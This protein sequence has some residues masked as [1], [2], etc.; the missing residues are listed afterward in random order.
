MSRDSDLRQ[1]LRLIVLTHPRPAGGSLVEVVAECLT[2]TTAELAA[3][4]TA[5]ATRLFKLPISESCCS[6]ARPPGR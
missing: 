3:A 6:A 5:N 2:I 1:Q 4:S